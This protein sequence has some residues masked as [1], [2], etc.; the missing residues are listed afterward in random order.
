MAGKMKDRKDGKCFVLRNSKGQPYLICHNKKEL[1]KQK[2]LTD[3]N[4]KKAEKKIKDREAKMKK[5]AA[6][7]KAKGLPPLKPAKKKPKKSKK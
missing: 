5:I 7:R 2:K 1:A 4:K 6:E 3:A